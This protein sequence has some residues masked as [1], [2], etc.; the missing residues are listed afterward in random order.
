MKNLLL[1]SML[2]VS[3]RE[4]SARK[5]EFHK[6]ATILQGTNDTG[7]SHLIKSIYYAFGAETPKINKK[8]KNADPSVFVEFKVDGVG[9]SILR[10]RNFFT[11]FNED[12]E[13]DG[14]FTS[15]TNELAP[16]LAKLFGFNLK[17]TDHHGVSSIATPAF[18][19]LPY[20][21]D[22]DQGWGDY[23]GSFNR[24]S[25]FKNYRPTI[26]G[27]HLG[28]RPDKWYEL[29]AKRL[30]ALSS[31]EEPNRQLASLDKIL[32][33]SR[34]KL[35]VTD[36]NFDVKKF[37]KEVEKLLV[38]CDGL[39]K[40]EDEFKFKMNSLRT[41][42]IRLEAQIEIVSRTQ[43]EL[44]K[45]YKFA[46]K[47]DGGS[48]DCPTCGAD[49]NNSFLE[50]FEI[51]RDAE[52]C[53]DLVESLRGDLRTNQG[54]IERTNAALSNVLA[55]QQSIQKTINRKRGK[56]KLKDLIEIRGKQSFVKQLAIEVAEQRRVL[57]KLTNKVEKIECK[58]AKY[59]DPVR[60]K[61]IKSKYA[62]DFFSNAT[63]LSTSTLD[64]AAVA[65]PEAKISESGSDL[66]RAIMAQCYAVLAIVHEN[67]NSTFCPIV[68]DAPNQQ[69][70]D[71]GNLKD[72]LEFISRN[73][74]SGSQLIV[75]LVDDAGV[76]FGGKVITLN[77]KWKVLRD[78]DYKKLAAELSRFESASL[79]ATDM[80]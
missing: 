39:K 28:L 78:E 32:K 73:R 68:I 75:A 25:Q 53:I 77:K 43:A 44:S 69:E 13:V 41:E 55:V 34:K 70:Q 31:Q 29:N 58:M 18:L 22:Q 59:D 16:R 62:E 47:L 24:L 12:G 71:K 1:E 42:K 66:S 50:R 8:W 15:V 74:P 60:K 48:V 27:Y 14:V 72:V 21:I 80:L 67:S 11:L 65:K 49:Y 56:L 51:A 30:K 5:I 54:E 36:F 10:K 40:Q 33:R 76:E 20:Y 46:S 64:E 57:G 23:W 52:T 38:Q 63:K 37:K 2:I 7:K 45:D 61:R 79:A 3:H 17:L 26:V 9:Y 6:S 35:A 4:R 19:F